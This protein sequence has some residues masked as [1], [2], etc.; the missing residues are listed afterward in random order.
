MRREY[1]LRVRAAR[2]MPARG[3]RRRRVG[4]RS[5][6]RTRRSADAFRIDE[7]QIEPDKSSDAVGADERGRDGHEE[8]ARH[9]D[10]G[11]STLPSALRE[12]SEHTGLRCT[13]EER[14]ERGHA[15]SRQARARRVSRA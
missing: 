14:R 12:R 7:D 15:G 3:R 5:E 8:H 10:A 6:P 4:A 13:E 11:D 1:A 9:E 2:P